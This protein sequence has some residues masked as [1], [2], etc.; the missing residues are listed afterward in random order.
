MKTS[1]GSIS[2]SNQFIKKEIIE[3]VLHPYHFG[4]KSENKVRENSH[5]PHRRDKLRTGII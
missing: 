2:K 5:T 1:S 3:G 4:W